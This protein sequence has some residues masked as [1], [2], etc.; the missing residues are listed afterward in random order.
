[1]LTRIEES[2]ILLAAY[3]PTLFDKGGR[4]VDVLVLDGASGNTNVR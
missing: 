4:V 2:V 1:M 3:G